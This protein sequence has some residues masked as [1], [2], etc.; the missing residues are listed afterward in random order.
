MTWIELFDS[1]HTVA[2]TPERDDAIAARREWHRVHSHRLLFE[3]H[4]VSQ[5][6]LLRSVSECTSVSER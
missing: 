6:H 5:C 1:H 2:N 3:H 4:Q